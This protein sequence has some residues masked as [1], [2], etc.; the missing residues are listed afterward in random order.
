MSKEERQTLLKNQNWY[1]LFVKRVLLLR[2][3][4][5]LEGLI[6]GEYRYNM[7]NGAFAWSESQEG[8]DYWH[9]ISTEWRKLVRDVS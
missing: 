2:S 3:S 6:E 5:R 1:K 4:I 8:Y 7:I 9:E